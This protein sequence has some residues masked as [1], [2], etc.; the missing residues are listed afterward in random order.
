[1]SKANDRPGQ[2]PSQTIGPF[3]SFGMAPRNDLV[4]EQTTGE[5]ILIEGRVLDGEG[6]PVLDALVEIWQADAGGIYA[7][8]ADAQSEEADPHFSGFGRSE[9]TNEGRFWFKTVRPGP[10]PGEA[11]EQ[12]P[13]INVTV[14]ARGMLIHAVTRF[15]FE[16]ELTNE[17]DPVLSAVPEERRHTLLAHREESPEGLAR[18]CF[19]IV[20]QGEG[21][22]VFFDV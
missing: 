20:L 8:P 11:G 14:F 16:D 15:Y 4:E 7:H 9:T 6:E 2:T 22:T 19:D 10:T 3:F 13:H 1:M 18:Y 17:S 5:R 12:A 21:E